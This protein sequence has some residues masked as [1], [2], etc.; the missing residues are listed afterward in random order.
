M[1]RVK[2]SVASKKRKK[3]VLRNAKGY[4]GAKSRRYKAANEQ[5][6]HAKDDSFAHRRKKKS[7]FRKL[8]IA[9]I[10]A[11]ARQE[12]ITYSVFINGLNKAGIKVDRK[13]L[14]HLAVNE[15]D[16]FKKLVKEAMKHIDA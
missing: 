4:T 3:K 5:V 16:S 8:W 6:M 1:V 12:G 2:N 14:A 11:A 9:R 15:P 7:D 10:N 13:I